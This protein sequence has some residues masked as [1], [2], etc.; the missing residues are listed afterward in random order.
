MIVLKDYQVAHTDR[1]V[2]LLQTNRVA[3]DTSGT[4]TGKTFMSLYAAKT[5][6]WTVYVVSPKSMCFVWEALIEKFH[7]PCSGV[8]SYEMLFRH[9]RQ[10]LPSN[11][12]IIF[13][14]CHYLKNDTKRFRSALTFLKRNK[15]QRL[16]MLS[17]TP[18]DKDG[19]SEQFLQL[20]KSMGGVGYFKR[21]VSS[22]VLEN[23]R[24]LEVTNGFY[25]FDN[26]SAT[27]Y[28]K[29]ASALGMVASGYGQPQEHLPPNMVGRLT[30]IGT[31][32]SHEGSLSTVIRLAHDILRRNNNSKVVLIGKYTAHLKE[33]ES[34]MSGFG[35]LFM[36]GQTTNRQHILEMFQAPNLLYRVMI[37]SAQVGGVGV[38]LDDQH[39]GFPRTMIIMPTFDGIDVIQCMG[40]IYRANT[41]SHASVS[42][43]YCNSVKSPIYKNL[44]RKVDKLA[45]M[46]PSVESLTFSDYK[47]LSCFET[48]RLREIL[49]ILLQ[50]FPRGEIGLL[51]M[52]IDEYH[53]ANIWMELEFVLALK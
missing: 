11:S 41:K 27:T 10:I 39:G 36:N 1:I 35:T 31:R 53:P 50:V 28:Q 52:M 51:P 44:L 6:N 47:E 22:T 42:V 48:I 25:T 21:A 16:L 12:L 4:G 46:S 33:F 14:E 9:P 3:I 49:K 38:S 24:K 8:L 23:S 19:C 20:Y 40:R 43:V 29:G 17:A 30:T 45:E 32:Y 18:F 7:I 2:S 34:A 15:T 26:E 5:N 13:D 37:T